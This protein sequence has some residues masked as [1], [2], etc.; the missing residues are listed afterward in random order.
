MPVPVARD[1]DTMA[2]YFLPGPADQVHGHFRPE[3]KWLLRTKLQA[4]LP[5]ADVMR[6]EGKLRPIFLNLC[7]LKNPRG[8]EFA[9][10]HNLDMSNLSYKG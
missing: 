10:A 1:D 6:G 8:V 2:M 7:R 4:V 5:N 3:R 9:G